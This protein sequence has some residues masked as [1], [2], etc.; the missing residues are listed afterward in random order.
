MT[1]EA[2]LAEFKDVH[3]RFVDVSAQAEEHANKAP[4]ELRDLHVRFSEVAGKAK[5]ADNS[6]E[7]VRQQCVKSVK[8]AG[9]ELRQ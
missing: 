3:T 4:T 1:L 2:E 6:L 7:K 8:A 5:V 9:E